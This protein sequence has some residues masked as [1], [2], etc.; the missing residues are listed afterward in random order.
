LTVF[1]RQGG[2]ITKL[3][4]TSG[5]GNP[6]DQGLHKQGPIPEGT[7]IFHP[8]E[9]SKAGLFRW[10][11]GDWGEW[12]VP[13]KPTHDTPTFGRDHFFIHGGDRP[14]SAGCIDVGKFDTALHDMFKDH[15]G[16][17]EVMVDYSTKPQAR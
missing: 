9:F 17:V 3:P 6:A 7:Y 15:Q 14:G 16:H 5:S 4:A 11:T 10:L 1:D 8:V 12:R 2:E 13:L